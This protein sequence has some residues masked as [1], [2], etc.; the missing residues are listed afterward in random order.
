MQW[1]I[2][3][4]LRVYQKHQLREIKGAGIGAGHH[5]IA[6]RK[7]VDVW[8]WID[9]ADITESLPPVARDCTPAKA[10][11]AEEESGLEHTAAIIEAH[12]HLISAPGGGGLALGKKRIG[13]AF[14]VR[15]PV[16]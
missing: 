3:D 13:A 15:A 7:A 5:R 16:I 8:S 11:A 6:Q 2:M 1:K 4:I 9:E 12:H 10:R 14:Q